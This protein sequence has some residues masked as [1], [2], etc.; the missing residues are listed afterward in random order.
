MTEAEAIH[1]RLTEAR[2][3]AY[4][5]LFGGEPDAVFPAHQL[6]NGPDDPYLIDVFVYSFEIEGRDEP[7]YAAV[8][9]GMSDHRM[10]EGDDPDQPRRREL[11]QYFRDCTPGH[12]KRLRDMAWLPL[13]DRFLLDSHHTLAWEWPAVE[14]APWKNALFLSPILRPHREVTFD[15]EGDEVS[16]LWHVPLSDAERAYHQEHGVDALLDRMQEVELPWVFD[17][18][19][20]PPLVD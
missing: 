15:V 3:E 20:R 17:E 16:L 10:P 12:A 2:A 6:R 4:E 18:A 7:I 13:F 19:D 8:T 11:I 5:E 1:R 9:N 14:G